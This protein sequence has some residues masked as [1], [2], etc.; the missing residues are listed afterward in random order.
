LSSRD[1]WGYTPAHWAALDGN[2]EFMRYLVERSAPVDLSCLGT[3][4]PRPIHWA[5]RKGHA[6]VVQVLLSVRSC[7]RSF[8]K[9]MRIVNIYEQCKGQSC[10]P[11][12]SCSSREIGIT[13]LVLTI[14]LTFVMLCSNVDISKC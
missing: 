7:I 4:G 6:A 12:F 1:E 11:L 8:L 5:C 9:C 10:E 3:Q 2:V 13:M 14:F